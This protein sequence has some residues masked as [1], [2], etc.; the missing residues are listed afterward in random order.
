MTGEAEPTDH[1]DAEEL[2]ES[3]LD[4]ARALGVK[5]WNTREEPFRGFGSPPGKF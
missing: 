3:L 4:V 2:Y 5:R 1:H